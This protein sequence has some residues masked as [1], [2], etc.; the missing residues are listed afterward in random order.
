ML[1]HIPKSREQFNLV[2]AGDEFH[3]TR[4]TRLRLIIF[5]GKQ[6]LPA[7]GVG[8]QH[9]DAHDLRGEGPQ[10]ELVPDFREPSGARGFLGDLLRIPEKIFLLRFVE[11]FEGQRGGFDV[12]NQCRHGTEGGVD[13]PTRMESLFK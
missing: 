10:I 7:R 11:V 13:K 12:K 8:V 1:R 6:N 5:S 4:I 9:G 3:R 2:G